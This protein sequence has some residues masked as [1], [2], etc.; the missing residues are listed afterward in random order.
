MKKVISIFIAVAMLFSVFAMTGSVSANT[1]YSGKA[2]VKAARMYKG[3][4]YVAGSNILAKHG[5]SET[6]TSGFVMLLFKKHA[7]IKLPRTVSGQEKCGKKTNRKL[8]G[9]GN[10]ALKKARLG[11]LLIYHNSDHVGIFSG[12]TKKGKY[13]Q[14]HCTKGWGKEGIMETV[15]HRDVYKIVRVKGIN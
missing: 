8:V 4:K 6:D 5:K 11:D 9:Y 3:G 7:K 12:K 15:L 1:K 2:L 13:K 10:K 14:I